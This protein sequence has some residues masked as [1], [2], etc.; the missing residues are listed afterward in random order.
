MLGKEYID[1]VLKDA[2][3][4]PVKASEFKDYPEEVLNYKISGWS[5]AECFEHLL[6]INQPY[7]PTFE[8]ILKLYAD[9]A[10]KEFK[11]SFIGKYL[12]KSIHPDAS[13]KVKTFSNFIPSGTDLSKGIID[14]YLNQ[15]FIIKGY[16]EKFRNF[17]LRNIK[18][19]SPM[20][21]FVKY[22]LGDAC[23]II[24]YHDLRHLKQAERAVKK[25]EEKTV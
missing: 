18:I 9:S 5:A 3:A 12:I 2:E 10:D 4:I 6:K 15:H 11:N 20:S 16:I 22:N 21:S 17:D 1:I 19:K 24:I 23:R 8:N 13:L 25:F 7:I 14:D